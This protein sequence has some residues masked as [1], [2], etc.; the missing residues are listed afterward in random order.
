MAGMWRARPPGPFKKSQKDLNNFE[1]YI[2]LM[3]LLFQTETAEN[4]IYDNLYRKNLNSNFRRTIYGQQGAAIYSYNW[5][6]GDYYLTEVNLGYDRYVAAISGSAYF[7]ERDL[8]RRLESLQF[9]KGG[10]EQREAEESDS[11]DDSAESE[12]SANPNDSTEVD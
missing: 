6:S 3:Q 12:E 5:W 8:I 1:K 9:T 10:Y 4:Q 11:S 2:I 7:S